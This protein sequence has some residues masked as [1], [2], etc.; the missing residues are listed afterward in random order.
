MFIIIFHLQVEVE[1][2]LSHIEEDEDS[3]ESESDMGEVDHDDKGGIPTKSLAVAQENDSDEELETFNAD[4]NI[5]SK[6][7]KGKANYENN[8]S[9]ELSAIKPDD[10]QEISGIVESV[11]AEQIQIVG[12]EN[13]KTVGSQPPLK[14]T[15]KA[16]KPVARSLIESMAA[17]V[18]SVQSDSFGSHTRSEANQ[19]KVIDLSKEIAAAAAASA[20]GEDGDEFL[21]SCFILIE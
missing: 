19:P 13:P 21:I 15:D 4:G 3:S 6:S 18:E 16:T 14:K 17:A 9:I 12:T 2:S 8:G 11:A 5:A 1:G 20:E 7:V 10:T